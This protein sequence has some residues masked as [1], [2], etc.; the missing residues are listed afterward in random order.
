MEG[1]EE[2]EGAVSVSSVPLVLLGILSISE[3]VLQEIAVKMRAEGSEG[4][5]QVKVWWHAPSEA[6][7]QSI[8]CP[9]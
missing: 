2:Q 1:N 3:G 7:L 8:D 4:P 9:L 6:V 5:C